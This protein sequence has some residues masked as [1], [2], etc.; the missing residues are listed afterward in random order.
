MDPNTFCPKL[1]YYSFCDVSS[2][3]GR[4]KASHIGLIALALILGA[5]KFLQDLLTLSNLTTRHYNPGAEIV[6]EAIIMT[7]NQEYPLFKDGDV[8]ITSPFGK[9]WKLHSQVLRKCSGAFLYLLQDEVQQQDNPKKESVEYRVMNGSVKWELQI[10]LSHKLSV[11]P[12]TFV[13]FL[14][15]RN[16]EKAPKQFSGRQNNVSFVVCLSVQAMPADPSCHS[17]LD[18]LFRCFYNL[19]PNLGWTQLCYVIIPNSLA[20]LEVAEH[21]Y[22]M[23]GVRLIIEKHL[24]CKEG[25]FWQ[26][27]YWKP[28]CWASN[29]ILMRSPAIFREA[30]I[31]LVGTF[32]AEDGVNNVELLEMGDVGTCILDTVEGKF[33]QLS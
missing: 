25:D 15:P 28:E 24:L 16:L 2:P 23:E 14:I 27:V 7:T 32:T 11:K 18:N 12:Q 33:N 30:I 10:E 20:L 13:K 1:A 6:D 26:N 8:T 3:P 4:G 9:V 21:L 29:A 31:H 5:P 22:A 19:E 17:V